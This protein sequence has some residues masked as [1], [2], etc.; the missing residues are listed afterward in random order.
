MRNPHHVYL[1]HV[2]N[3][4]QQEPSAWPFVKPVDGNVVHDYYD[5]IVN[6]MGQLYDASR[7]QQLISFRSVDNGEQAGK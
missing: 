2:L 6:P 7:P 5:V 1:Q 4:L 3:D